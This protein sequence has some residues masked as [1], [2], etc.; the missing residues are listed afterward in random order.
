[1][2]RSAA[3]AAGVAAWEAGDFEGLAGFLHP[4]V[5]L[6]AHEPGP[7]D[8]HGRDTV[9][10]LL[11]ERRAEGSQPFVVRIDDVDD[12][13]IVISRQVQGAWKEWATLATI[14]DDRV[15]VM[16]QFPTREAALAAATG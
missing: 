8:C 7:W 11:R 9:I 1:M 6:L 3:V 15:T 12:H 5:K 4:D 13:T 10:A 16:R 2:A 14:E